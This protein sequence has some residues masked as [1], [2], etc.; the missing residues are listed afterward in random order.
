MNLTP[1]N[2]YSREANEAW[3][4]YSQYSM[5]ER[6]ESAA[7][8]CIH[9]DYS[10]YASTALLFGGYV[11]AYFSG[12]LEQFAEEN[13]ELF[14]SRGPTKGQL[15]AE[16]RQADEVIARME[17]DP[18]FMTFLEGDKQTIL[19]GEINGVP[20]R[21]KL[22]V[23]GGDRIV[24]LKT[25]RDF[26]DVWYED[27]RARVS[28]IRRWGYDTQA[29]IYTELVRQKT[30]KTLPYYIAAV[31][32]ETVPDI[33]VIQIHPRIIEDRLREVENRAP[34]FQA[35]KM[36]LMAPDKCGRCDWCKQTKVLTDVEVYGAMQDELT[37]SDFII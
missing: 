12:E 15:K 1:E 22:D 24:D 28:W 5:F 26:E 9:E 18:F 32:K 27:E 23:F 33:A 11:D 37:V 35:L 29:A 17:R 21:G 25:V 31:T 13:P 20:F 4:S 14:S 16:F 30:G 36:Q 2:Y 10:P 7:I 8:A 6:C 19:T 3:M 34:Y